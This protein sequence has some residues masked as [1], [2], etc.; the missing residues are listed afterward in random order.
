VLSIEDYAFIYCNNLNTIDLSNVESIG[1][2]AFNEC[3]NL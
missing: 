1:N 2:A 3:K